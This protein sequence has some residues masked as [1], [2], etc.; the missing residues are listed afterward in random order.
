MLISGYLKWLG[1]GTWVG[2]EFKEFEELQE[3]KERRARNGGMVREKCL[4][5]PARF[6]P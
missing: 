1:F 5:F 4:A 2:E 3:F 6:R